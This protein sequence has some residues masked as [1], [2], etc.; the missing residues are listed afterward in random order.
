MRHALC[1]DEL[2]AYASDQLNPPEPRM[3]AG[4]RAEALCELAAEER[5]PRAISVEQ[6]HVA[7]AGLG[8]RRWRDPRRLCSLLDPDGGVLREQPIDDL[9]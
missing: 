8:C 9:E 1:T 5:R 2:F 4:A 3:L 7:T 6:L